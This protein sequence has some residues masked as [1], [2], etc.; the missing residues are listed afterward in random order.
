[1]LKDFFLHKPSSSNSADSFARKFIHPSTWH[2]PWSGISQETKQSIPEIS[3]ETAALLTYNTYGH[4]PQQRVVN[5]HGQFNLTT[6]EYR[7]LKDL[8]NRRDLIIKSADKGGAIVVMDRELYIAEGLRQLNNKNYYKPL[9]EPLFH[10]SAALIRNQL[11]RLLDRGYINDKQF[12]YLSPPVELKQRQFY[13]LPKIHK[14][15]D[16]WP[17]PK[18]PEG[19]PIVS[20]VNSETYTICQYID[21]Y[22]QPLATQHASYV[23]DSYDFVEKIRNTEIDK[24]DLIVTGDVTALYTNMKI[25]R[26]LDSIRHIFHLYPATGRPDEELLN[27]LEITLTRNDFSFGHNIYLQICGTAMGKGYA[28]SLANIY[29]IKFDEA[30]RTG[31]HIKPK[32]Y[33]RYLDD[34]HLIW[35]GTAAQLKEYENFLNSIIPGITVCLVAKENINEFLDTR[36]YKYRTPENKY[37]VKTKIF[38]KST[39]THQLLHKKSYHPK[40]TFKGLLKSQF[41]RFKRISSF[42]IEY[43][44]ACRT[45]GRVLQ[46][47]GYS[48]RLFRTIKRQVWQ[49]NTNTEVG[50]ALNTQEK[51]L[52]L[53]PVITHYDKISSTLNRKWK[54]IVANNSVL[55]GHF[56]TISAYRIHKNL[57][58]HLTRSALSSYITEENT[59]ATQTNLGCKRCI[60]TR[61]KACTYIKEA[62][63]FKSSHTGQTFKITDVLNCKSTNIVYLTTCSKCNKQYVGET[64]RMLA[65]R[66][67]DHMSNIRLA[68]DTPTGLHFNSPGHS[69]KHFSIQ[70]IEQIRSSDHKA[71]DTRRNRELLW[72]RLLHTAHPLGLNNLNK[73]NICPTPTHT[74]QY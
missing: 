44:E 60:S 62:S 35:P 3:K 48:S 2:P 26:I 56:R 29:L 65:Q 30:A 25:D 8:K 15:R 59:S 58:Q 28:P 43:E 6:E 18:M 20:D 45:L 36:T 22:L 17:N 71:T 53:L 64:G 7:A 5:K 70:A 12:N 13:L 55:N 52:Q 41:I 34:I 27:L 57:S 1:M 37:L 47:R 23:K 11:I 54:A 4:G 61:C 50:T 68:K 9:T 46:K 67:T 33:W 66:I 40:H 32:T 24:S 72:Q 42:K 19:R 39:D 38:F 63:T 31:F 51:P 73:D 21:Y 14:N 49:D 16:K 74:E 69:V 10:E